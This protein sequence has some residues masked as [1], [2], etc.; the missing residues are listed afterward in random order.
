MNYNKKKI[1]ELLVDVG[2]ISQQQL[3]YALQLQ[4]LTGKK[5]GEL[6]IEQ[7]MVEEKDII[8]VLK[9]QMDIVYIELDKEYI[10]PEVPR[11]IPEAL[12]RRHVLLPIKNEDGLLHVVMADPLNLVAIDDVQIATGLRIE[13]LISTSQDILNAIDRLYRKQNTEEAMEE[14]K[15]QYENELE[16]IKDLDEETINKINNAPLVR[17]VNSIIK[18]AIILKASDI[19]IE[20]FEKLLRIRFRIDGDLHEILTPEKTSHPAIVTR[21]KIMGKMDIAEKRLPQDGRVEMIIDNRQVD[22][23]ISVLPTAYGEKV[24]IRLLDRGNFLI[25]KDQLGFSKYDMEVFEN[26]I[27]NPNGIILVTGPTGSGKS[28]TLYAILQDLNKINKNIITVEDPIEYR[29]E[30]INQVQVNTKAGLTFA[31][32]LRSILRQDPDIIM[33]GDKQGDGSVFYGGKWC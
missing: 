6:M 10:D 1:G 24:V 19:H 15:K 16:N 13:P 21:I 27:R 31:T 33:I 7:G 5:I 3:K 32:G 2:V 23:R 18:Q 29:M 26:I 20:P 4:R 12:A 17:L 28:T 25:S 8:E 9:N 11:L 14:F 30:G 22:L